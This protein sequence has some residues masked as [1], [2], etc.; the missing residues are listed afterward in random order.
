MFINKLRMPITAQQNAKIVEPGDDALQFYAIDQ[1]YRQR[2]FGF[3]HMIEK[4]I[5]QAC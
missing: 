1:K 3:A 4:G 2:R 5:L